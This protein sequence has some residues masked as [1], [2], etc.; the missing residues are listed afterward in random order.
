VGTL[1]F[2]D[3]PAHLPELSPDCRIALHGGHDARDHPSHVLLDLRDH[4]AA[5]GAPPGSRAAPGDRPVVVGRQRGACAVV[6][7]LVGRPCLACLDPDALALAAA[8]DTPA[9]F[10]PTALALGALAAGEVLRA[11]LGVAATGRL[12][13][14]A[15]DDGTLRTTPLGP[16]RT[17]SVC[18]AGA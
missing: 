5:P 8:G 17:C 12:H 3:G 6:A 13:V 15:L 11:L 1:D 2:L 10:E 9:L 7:L 4:P 18:G 14:L 16:G